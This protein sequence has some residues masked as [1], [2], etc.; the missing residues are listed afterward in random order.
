MIHENADVKNLVTRSLEVSLDNF[1]NK[2]QMGQE[3]I[4]SQSSIPYLERKIP[5]LKKLAL[6]LFKVKL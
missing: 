6:N 2:L 3:E 1:S 4:R 5:N